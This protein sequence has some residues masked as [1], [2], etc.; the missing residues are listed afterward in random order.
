MKPIGVTFTPVKWAKWLLERHGVFQAWLEGA[1][2]CDPTAGEGA[3]ALALLELAKEHN[4]P[5]TPD[6]VQR[7]SLIEINGA[8]L[9]NFLAKTAFRFGFLF[10]RSNIFPQDIIL[11]QHPGR[12]DILMGNPPWQNFTDLPQNYKEMLKPVFVNSGLVTNAKK[13]LLGS[14]R[15]D[16]AALVLKTVLG[17]LLKPNGKACFFLPLSLF[18]G[19]SAHEGFRDYFSWG[20]PFKVTEVYEFATPSEVFEDIST[21]YCSAYINMDETQ[22]FPV[23][24]IRRT[25]GQEKQMYAFPLLEPNSQ[26]RITDSP[27]ESTTRK[28]DIQLPK[29][30]KPRQGANT[31][32]VNQILLFDKYPDFL[33]NDFVFPLATHANWQEEE[34]VPHRWIL[35]PYSRETGKP[36][37]WKEIKQYPQLSEYLQDNRQSLEKRKGTLISAAISKGTWWA[38]LGVGPYSFTRHKIIWESFGKNNFLP[39]VFGCVNGQP[40]QGNQALHAL[41]PCPSHEQAAEL[42]QKLYS[43]KITKLLRELNG[44]GKC[45]WAQPGKIAR[46]LT[47][48]DEG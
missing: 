2:V 34:P 24:Y 25:K 44:A 9:E 31:C 16:I 1:T 37:S 38:L 47:F 42:C 46:L 20:R 12:Y 21:S 27:A 39:K 40:W 6:L 29:S 17:Y 28:L 23:S 41:I 11:Q 8:Y 36:L 14:S 15:T 26:W 13:M 5:L 32:G 18:T 10:P 45:N 22:T 3:F 35:L 33:P 4:V 19:D 48:Q 30:Q 7:I 43:A